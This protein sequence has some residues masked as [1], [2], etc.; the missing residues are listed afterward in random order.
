[1]TQTAVDILTKKLNEMETLLQK[2]LK[3]KHSLEH[4][5]KLKAAA[6]FVDR[7]KCLWLRKSFPISTFKDTRLA[8]PGGPVGDDQPMT[9]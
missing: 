3:T 6:L 8:K 7:E 5:L 4:D 9:R 1:M 2:L